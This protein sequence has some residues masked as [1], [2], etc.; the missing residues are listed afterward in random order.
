MEFRDYYEVLGLD[1]SATEAEIKKAYRKMAK[2]NHPDLHPDDPKAQEK[3]A[4]IAEAY[5][6]LSD[7][8]KRKKYDQFGHNMN[9]QDGQNFDPSSYGF[10]P[11]A[12]YTY[13]SSDAG[14]FSDFFNMIFGNRAQSGD[15]S[16]FGSFFS[17][18]RGPSG[19][20]AGYGDVGAGAYR[21]RYDTK[22]NISLYEAYRGG[23]RSVRYRLEDREVDVLIKWPAG[24]EDGKSIKVRA[25]K[26]GMEADIYV[27]L[28]V[29]DWD[30]LDG[31]DWIKK[32]DIY[33]WDAA[34]GT[35]KI[36]DTFEGRINLKIP[37]DSSPHKR[38]RIP[39]KGFKNR[40]GETG[41]LYIEVEIVNPK[42][43]TDK[44][45]DLYEKLRKLENE[46]D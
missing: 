30:Q 43:L 45:K 27:K 25:D 24:I 33:P 5:E 16:G 31:L 21:P 29:D 2:E 6:V 36:I 17:R 10:D 15:A 4:E 1:K 44:Q 26:F 38:I 19:A 11:N 28:A 13:T 9:F 37:K 3:F 8:D 46:E 20:S 18:R 32:V 14:G 23:E 22:L 41:D 40:N 7:A 39:Q 12:S 34:F 35:K 42:K